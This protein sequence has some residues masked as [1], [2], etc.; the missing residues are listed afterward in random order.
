MQNYCICSQLHPPTN[1][2]AIVF[3]TGLLQVLVKNFWRKKTI[4]NPYMSAFSLNDFCSDLDISICRICRLSNVHNSS[5]RLL[6]S[7]FLHLSWS[8]KWGGGA[9][10]SCITHQLQTHGLFHFS[11]RKHTKTLIQK[12]VDARSCRKMKLIS[13]LWARDTD[14]GGEMQEVEMKVNLGKRRER[15]WK[16]SSGKAR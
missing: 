7:I 6:N 5:P 15:N 3:L 12:K 13:L 14:R 16:L 4:I 8:P 1:G 11:Q 9:I 10:F 2:L